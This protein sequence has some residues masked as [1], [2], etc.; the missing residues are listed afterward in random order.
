MEIDKNWEENLK[1]IIIIFFLC[2]K[3]GFSENGKYHNKI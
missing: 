2:K 3:A 1:G